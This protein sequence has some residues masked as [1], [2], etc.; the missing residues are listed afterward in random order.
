MNPPPD[1]PLDVDA[2][3]RLYAFLKR[4]PGAHFSEVQRRLEMA[5]GTLQYHLHYLEK[6]GLIDARREGRYTRYYPTSDVDRRDKPVLGLLRQET[7]RAILLDLVEH[8][9]SRL[10]D[11]SE[12]L[13][14]VPSTLSFHL[15]KL[16]EAEVVER[17]SRGVYAVREADAVVDLLVSYRA[18]FLDAAVDRIV[19][20]FTGVRGGRVRESGGEREEGNP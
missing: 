17:P 14:V 15:K 7:P 19:G 4:T 11:L 10:T 9:P 3:R 1:D 6:R 12:R 18:S 5:T 8:G 13:G 16:Q 20:L 2:R